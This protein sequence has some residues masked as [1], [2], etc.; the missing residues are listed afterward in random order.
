MNTISVIV[1]VL[2]DA[3]CL[4]INKGQFGDIAN[5]GIEVII[6]DGGSSD[7][8]AEFARHL[9]LKVLTTRPGRGWQLAQGVEHASG[10][11]LV[12][13][14]VDTKLPADSIEHLQRI[15]TSPQAQ[16]GYFSLRLS[17][18]KAI[19]QCISACM[20]LRT[21][22]SHVITGDHVLFVKRSLYEEIGG[23]PDFPIMEDVAISKKLR[24]KAKPVLIKSPVI[25]SSRR[26]EINGV[27]PTILKMWC[28]RLLYFIGVPPRQLAKYY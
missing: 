14:H 19:Y 27:V 11:L 24:Q 20:N 9:G 10:D 5:A 18:D 8:S 12:F 13:L 21:R 6:V 15:L 28:F 2:N 26:W 23:F 16:W 3:S 4:E 25:T 7:N 1:P 22:M 17:S